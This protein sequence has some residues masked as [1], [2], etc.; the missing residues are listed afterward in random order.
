MDHEKILETAF[1]D[2][3]N[4][5]ITLPPANVNKEIFNLKKDGAKETFVR[6]SD[7]KTWK[8]ASQYTKVI[9]QVLLD[10]DTGRA[11]FIGVDEV[12]APDGRKIL[13]GQEQ[14]RF[15]VEHS[16][17]GNESE[18]LNIWRIVHLD[19]DEDGGLRETFGNMA[20]SP[21]LREFSEVYIRE[22][23]GRELTRLEVSQ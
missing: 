6:V 16:V 13:R 8:D 23:L 10:H 11:I 18:P 12:E 4:T 5:A 1:A 9:E 15:H 14:P 7:Q 2:P 17:A 22:D 20:E 21:Y 3:N 19:N